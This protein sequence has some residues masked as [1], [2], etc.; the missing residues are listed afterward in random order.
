[1]L[2]T[3]DM[4]RRLVVSDDQASSVFFLEEEKCVLF[5]AYHYYLSVLFQNIFRIIVLDV[6]EIK[7][8]DPGHWNDALKMY[9][10]TPCV[11]LV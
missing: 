1:M 2:T 5:C 7:I 6:S 10:I 4:R 8:F 9:S 11:M 3:A